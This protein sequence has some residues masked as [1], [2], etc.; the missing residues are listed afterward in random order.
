MAKK[1]AGAG[2]VDGK[3]A[4]RKKAKPIKAGAPAAKASKGAKVGKSVP[5]TRMAKVRKSTSKSAPT[6][7][8]EAGPAGA[9]PCCKDD[10]YVDAAGVLRVK[11]GG[12]GGS[13]VMAA[14][15][16]QPGEAPHPTLEKYVELALGLLPAA[17]NGGVAPTELNL[18]LCIPI[19]PD[20]ATAA[21]QQRDET[22]RALLLLFTFLTKTAVGTLGTNGSTCC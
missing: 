8:L 5:P 20:A 19:I 4:K 3:L 13:A 2:P 14:W 9:K 16:P 12:D 21:L 15:V 22:I 11:S 18:T 17:A 6:A 10:L 1:A 7:L